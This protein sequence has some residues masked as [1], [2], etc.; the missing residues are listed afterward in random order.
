MAVWHKRNPTGW[1]HP[2][3][4]LCI[5]GSMPCR[6]GERCR[7]AYAHVDGPLASSVLPR[8]APSDHIRPVGLCD[9]PPFAQPS[10]HSFSIVYGRPPRVYWL[11]HILRHLGSS[12]RRRAGASES[13]SGVATR[14]FRDGSPTVRRFHFPRPPFIALSCCA[15][16]GRRV[17]PSRS[18]FVRRLADVGAAH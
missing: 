10:R 6:V 17:K 15:R 7:P 1:Q 18:N 3:G 13:C 8:N 5:W 12:D 14:P 2:A 9:W 11:E 4:S 16:Q